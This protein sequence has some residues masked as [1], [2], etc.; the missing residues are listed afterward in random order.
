MAL[1]TETTKPDIWSAT[2]STCPRCWLRTFSIPEESQW[3]SN[4]SCSSIPCYTNGG[5]CPHYAHTMSQTGVLL[6]FPPS[7]QGQCWSNIKLAIH[8]QSFLPPHGTKRGDCQA[9]HTVSYEINL[10]VVLATNLL[11]WRRAN[12][13]HISA[14]IAFHVIL[15]EVPKHHKKK[16]KHR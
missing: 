7:D 2:R 4:V 5:P 15:A 10:S 12:R 8:S 16:D 6:F 3:I 11:V 13:S 14:A 9:R 1:S